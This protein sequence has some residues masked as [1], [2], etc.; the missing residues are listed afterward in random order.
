[1]ELERMLRQVGSGIFHARF[2]FF[3]ACHQLAIRYDFRIPIVR[4]DLDPARGVRITNPL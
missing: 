1:M 4:G 2:D 3:S